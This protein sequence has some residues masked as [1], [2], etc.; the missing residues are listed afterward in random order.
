MSGKYAGCA[1][2]SAGFLFMAAGRIHLAS[3]S[4][5]GRS[6]LVVTF[7]TA[8]LTLV[9]LRNPLE[10]SHEL[11]RRSRQVCRH[12]RHQPKKRPSDRRP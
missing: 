10:D 8:R 9:Q 11:S 3:L 4:R 1:G 7:D 5:L 12:V 6:H 2:G